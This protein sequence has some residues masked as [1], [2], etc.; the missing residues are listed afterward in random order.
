MADAAPSSSLHLELLASGFRA[1]DAE[2]LEHWTA[3]HCNEE[4]MRAARDG[5]QAEAYNKGGLCVGRAE[6]EGKGTADGD[7]L[8]ESEGGDEGEDMAGQAKVKG[9]GRV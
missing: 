2:A 7:E 5:A 6:V 4:C 1:H 9:D 8:G 3:A